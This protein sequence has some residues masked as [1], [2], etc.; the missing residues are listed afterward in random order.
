MALTIIQGAVVGAL[1]L[2]VPAGGYWLNQLGS[3]DVRFLRGT[4]ST[5]LAGSISGGSDEHD[6]RVR[7][8]AGQVLEVA[9][10]GSPDVAFD[11]LV[12]GTQTPLASGSAAADMRYPLAKG[13][14]Y[15]IRVHHG[16]DAVAADE[17]PF[18]LTI[19]LHDPA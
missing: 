13:G 16:A 6:Y 9:L 14:A 19:A 2:A 4:H 15:T 3:T 8:Q 17:T 1:A 11:L 18:D 10:D 7:A 5:T 12:P